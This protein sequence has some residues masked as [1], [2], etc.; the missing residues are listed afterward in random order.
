MATRDGQDMKDALRHP[1]EFLFSE[2]DRQRVL[3]AS[4]ERLAGDPTSA[5]TARLVLDYYE[6]E[7]PRHVA[8]EEEDL[9]PLLRARCEPDD[10]IGTI[11]D[12]LDAEH[13]TDHEIFH[14]LVPGLKAIAGGGRADAP[15]AFSADARAF[16]IL[17]R[18]H[19]AWE[20]GTVLPMARSR[21]GA[22]DQRSLARRMAARRGVTL[23]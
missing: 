10:A 19:L 6:E 18:R 21:L 9:F 22:D 4:L 8:D 12:L 5:E 16:S 20:N 7:L 23:D 11:L 14:R 17:Q 2:H 1:I 13:A 15:I 3:C